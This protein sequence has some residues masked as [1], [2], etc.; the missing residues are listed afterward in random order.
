MDAPLPARIARVLARD[1]SA[2]VC[3]PLRALPPASAPAPDFVVVALA[4]AWLHPDSMLLVEALA[5]ARRGAIL[6]GALGEGV[7]RQALVA[8][9]ERLCAELRLRPTWHDASGRRI[10]PRAADATD[11]L[12]IRAERLI[13]D[14][15][16]GA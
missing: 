12:V 6:H 7:E 11:E 16:S 4:F 13:G 2:F 8:R 9:I 3:E 14:R 10:D 1:E 15:A 5:C